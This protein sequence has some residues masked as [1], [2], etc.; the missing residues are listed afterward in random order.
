MREF[1]II[2]ELV[3]RLPAVTYVDSLDSTALQRIL[4]EPKDSLV[5][6]Y[7]ELLREDGIQL[8][9]TPEA[10]SAIAKKAGELGTG[11]RGLRS[12]M[13]SVMRNIMFTAPDMSGNNLEIVV[14]EKTVSM[15]NVKYLACD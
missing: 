11:A 12:I 5:S 14:S 2:P 3:G 6:Q 15:A 9:F 4:S 1:G 13:E 7:S 8:K 10:L